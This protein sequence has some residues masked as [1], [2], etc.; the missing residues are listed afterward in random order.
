MEENRRN[1]LKKLAAAA[2]LLGVLTETVGCALL[3]EKEKALA[4]L[5]E[6]Q[7][8]TFLL[9]EFNGDAIFTAL[10]PDGTPYT[11]SLICSHK[12]CT[13]KYYSDENKFVCPCHKGAYHKDGKVLSGKPPAPLRRFKTE[14]R[15]DVVWV[16]DETLPPA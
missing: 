7:E 15:K 12:K 3:D 11:L 2:P 10:A 13:V 14:I 9:N 5:K 16:L 1:F 4:P 8:K 6:L